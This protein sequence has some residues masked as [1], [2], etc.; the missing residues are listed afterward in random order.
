MHDASIFAAFGQSETQ[1][2]SPYKPQTSA[3]PHF[4]QN[5]KNYVFILMMKSKKVNR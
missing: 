2:N 3:L 4:F 1:K 5:R